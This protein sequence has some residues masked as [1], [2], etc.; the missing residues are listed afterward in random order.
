MYPITLWFSWNEYKQG[1][2]IDSVKDE[3][4]SA[5]WDSNYQYLVVKVE[6]VGNGYI[7]HL[8]KIKVNL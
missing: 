3:K 6:N 7:Y 1:D 5:V 8:A 2:F 4:L